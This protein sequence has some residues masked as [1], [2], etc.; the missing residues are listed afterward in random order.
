MQQPEE[1]QTHFNKNTLPAAAGNQ[2]KANDLKNKPVDQVGALGLRPTRLFRGQV[3]ADERIELRPK[4]II[5]HGTA[6]QGVKHRCVMGNV[7]WQNEF[8]QKF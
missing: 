5:S 8:G 2:D 3:K 7:T 4:A 6:S 1:A